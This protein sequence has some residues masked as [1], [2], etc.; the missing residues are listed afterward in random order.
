VSLA[1][2]GAAARFL[3]QVPGFRATQ[4]AAL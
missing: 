3:F 2:L 1:P 4:S